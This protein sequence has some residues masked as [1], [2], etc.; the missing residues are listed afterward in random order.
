MPRPVKPIV[1]AI[2]DKG[3]INV[4]PFDNT[5]NFGG[6]DLNKTGASF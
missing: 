4:Q 1:L 6:E 3:R 2:Q 5:A